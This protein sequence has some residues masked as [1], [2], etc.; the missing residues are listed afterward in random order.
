MPVVGLADETSVRGWLCGIS[1][2][3]SSRQEPFTTARPGGDG[4]PRGGVG[5]TL[6]FVCMESIHQSPHDAPSGLA[7]AFLPRSLKSVLWTLDNRGSCLAQAS[8]SILSLK[9]R[10][11][12][13]AFA[14]CELPA[15]SMS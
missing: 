13:C 7:A 10:L 2:V 14:S 15:A 4:F 3:R 1:L 5:S 8:S 11:P 6:T 9:L 12:S